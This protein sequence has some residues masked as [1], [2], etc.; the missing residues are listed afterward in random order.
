MVST[1]LDVVLLVAWGKYASFR[2]KAYL[3]VW[4]FDINIA[5]GV[6]TL[7]Q[8]VFTSMFNKN[9]VLNFPDADVLVS[10]FLAVLIRV[11][12]F[13][14]EVSQSKV[15]YPIPF[16]PLGKAVVVANRVFANFFFR[17]TQVY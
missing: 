1:K 10:V 8:E 17:G 9:A 11:S 5:V 14:E 13:C 2:T 7:G 16:S 15:S 12:C 3:V 6:L 4:D